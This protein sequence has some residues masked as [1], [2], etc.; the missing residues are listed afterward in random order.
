MKKIS[1]T[2]AIISFCYM[3]I[4]FQYTRYFELRNTIEYEY[5]MKLDFILLTKL[6]F[7]VPFSLVLGCSKVRCW[8]KLK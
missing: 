2:T 3:S 5:I 7:L 1:K 4:I 6:L 8:K